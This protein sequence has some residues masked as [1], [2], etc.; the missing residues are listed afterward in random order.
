MGHRSKAFL[1]HSFNFVKCLIKWLFDYKN[2]LF[3][4]NEKSFYSFMDLWH[5][6]VLEYAGFD[7]R[8]VWCARQLKI[9]GN[10]LS[11]FSVKVLG[12]VQSS[13]LFLENIHTLRM[14][15]LSHSLIPVHMKLLN[16][17]FPGL[18]C[19]LAFCSNPLA[20]IPAFTWKLSSWFLE[21]D[22]PRE[23]AFDDFTLELHPTLDHLYSHP[24]CLGAGDI[25]YLTLFWEMIKFT[26]LSLTLK[27]R[28]NRRDPEKV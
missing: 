1:N 8:N 11:Y 3:W 25:F 5:F 22:C 28:E 15:S 26:I 20:A 23:K 10:E 7:D 27:Y 9:D 24:I 17:L 13:T 6:S 2:N 4:E 12:V 14:L 18:F 19:P 16:C 21:H